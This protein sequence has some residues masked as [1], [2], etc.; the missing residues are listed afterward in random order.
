M[1]AIVAEW[2]SL[3]QSGMAVAW[4]SCHL[5]LGAVVTMPLSGTLCESSLGWPAAYYIQGVLTLVIFA[6][7]YWFYRDSAAEHE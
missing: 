6:V 2:S 7:F 5:Q 3:A 1:G 4:I